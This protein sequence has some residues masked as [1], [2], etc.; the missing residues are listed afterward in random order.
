MPWLQR[1]RPGDHRR[2]PPAGPGLLATG[3]LLLLSS[4]VAAQ[5]SSTPSQPP[6]AG[7]T[8]PAPPGAVP[9]PAGQPALA[10]TSR[11][12]ALEVR[13]AA[14]GEVA[15]RLGSALG[16]PL[17]VEA[18]LAEQR[19]MARAA[20]TTLTEVM[21]ASGQLLGSAWE[22][23]PTGGHR[24]PRGAAMETAA[25]Q[26]V[27]DRRSGLL[28]RLLAI[29]LA[30][31][32][33]TAPSYP[34]QLRASLAERRPDLP[35]D[36]LQEVDADYLS[37]TLL[38]GPLHGALE[39]SLTGAGF[40]ALP[41]RSLSSAYQELAVRFL[42]NHLA[43]AG[44]GGASPPDPA[45]ALQHAILTLNQPQARLEYRLFYGDEWAEELVVIRAGSPDHWATATLAG[46]LAALP[47][48]RSLYPQAE[49]AATGEEL[50]RPVPQSIPLAGQSVDQVLSALANAQGLQVMADSYARPPVFRPQPPGEIRAGTTVREAL[51]IVARAYGYFW[52][53]Q[54]GW[55]LFRHRLWPE[56][57]R[58]AV[59][60]SLLRSLG[61]VARAG[62]RLDHD[63]L[64]L[65]AE[66]SDE[67]LLS[68]NLAGRAEGRP[69]APVAALEL[70]QLDLARRGLQFYRS[71]TSPQRELAIGTGLPFSYLFPNQQ[72]EFAVLA[73]DYGYPVDPDAADSLSFRL[74]Q[75][76]A[77]GAGGALNGM[78]VFQ[79][80][81]APGVTRTAKLS[82]RLPAP[83]SPAPNASP[84][85]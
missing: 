34:A 67:Q 61:E 13:A 59:P 26:L 41:V 52:W 14:V 31:G 49:A 42:A 79:F 38:L 27:A 16:V 84:P 48:G 25:A 22:A 68:L 58:V 23:S 73:Y 7:P 83:P 55:Y 51:D 24:L 36:L 30:M 50:G 85:R 63:S 11:K 46:V 54:D 80:A 32:R 45:T 57:A 12:F 21:R 15:S 18:P 72:R 82:L 53:K 44:A 74:A 20:E 43:G 10:A 40:A 17:S 2:R 66:L 8:A 28:R 47:D 76:F 64:A 3:S 75:S 33:S 78:L 77:S 65:L 35:P 29:G 4:L 5:P 69:T 62:N 1:I 56:E 37:Y 71:L 19:I 9:T 60:D 81:L 70:G 39:R 6:P